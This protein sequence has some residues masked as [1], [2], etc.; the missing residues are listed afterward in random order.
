MGRI[1]QLLRWVLPISAAILLANHFTPW[2]YRQLPNDY[3]RTS[4]IIE[5]LADKTNSGLIYNFSSSGQ[6]LSESQLYYSQMPKS[7]KQVFQFAR[8]DELMQTPPVLQEAP[9]LR[10]C[11][12]GLTIS[13]LGLMDF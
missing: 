6:T 8:V 10:H 2:L 3:Y 13:H 5:A 4:L 11:I 1:I 12:L 9:Y 7:V